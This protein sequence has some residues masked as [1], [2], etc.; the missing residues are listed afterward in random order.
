MKIEEKRALLRK[1]LDHI[2]DTPEL[3]A[4][5]NRQAKIREEAIKNIDSFDLSLFD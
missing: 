2:L 5:L 4:W 1:C 3:L